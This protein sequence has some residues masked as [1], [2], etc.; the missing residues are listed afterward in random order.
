[1]SKFMPIPILVSAFL[2]GTVAAAPAPPGCRAVI[3]H[4]AWGAC[5][6]IILAGIGATLVR[7]L[8]RHGT[9]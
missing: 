9:T 1:M 3:S 7:R 2:I 8:Y 5:S 4:P 6:S